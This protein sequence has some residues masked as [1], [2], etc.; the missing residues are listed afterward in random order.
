M[1]THW[2]APDAFTESKPRIKAQTGLYTH[3]DV[4]LLEEQVAVVIDPPSEEQMSEI[5][6]IGPGPC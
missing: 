5:A 4:Q 3:P 2:P 1:E 6:N